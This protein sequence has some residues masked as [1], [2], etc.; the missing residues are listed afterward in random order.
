MG[1]VMTENKHEYAE[2]EWLRIDD[3]IQALVFF[4][5]LNSLRMRTEVGVLERSPWPKLPDVLLGGV[6]ICTTAI[7]EHKRWVMRAL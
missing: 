7:A 2:G 5:Y 6:R 4:S 3:I 1:I